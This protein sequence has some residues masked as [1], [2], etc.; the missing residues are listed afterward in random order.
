MPGNEISR[1]HG[2]TSQA[3][4]PNVN[5][6]YIHMGPSMMS[7]A[8]PNPYGYRD[9]SGH[10]ASTGWGSSQQGPWAQQWDQSAG[11][12]GVT[13]P[14]FWHPASMSRPV[15][16]AVVVLGFMFWWPVGLALLLY[17]IGS[18][19]MGCLS[20][21]SRAR[22]QGGQEAGTFNAWKSWAW[23][24]GSSSG[25]HA[26]DEYRAETLR[27][28]EE[29]QKEF[30]AFLER[31]RFAKDKAEFDQFMAERRNQGSSP[32]AEERPST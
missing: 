8:N 4:D 22:V 32:P 10:P 19:R 17:M 1:S 18:G 26:F 24:P 2:L 20:R 14:P 11:G 5:V 6:S 12:P 28:L 31:L 13:V 29:E 7:A 27:R 21:R 3:L 16:I 15:A 9:W 30:S 25:N 23:G